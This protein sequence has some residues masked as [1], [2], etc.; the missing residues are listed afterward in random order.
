MRTITGHFRIVVHA[1]V[2][3]SG[4]V[5]DANFKTRGPSQYFARLSM[6]AARQ[7]KFSPPM[8]NGTPSASEWLIRFKFS[9]DGIDSSAEQVSP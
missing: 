5:T 1:N 7:W 3:N 8:V 6:D 4:N 9:R 2:D